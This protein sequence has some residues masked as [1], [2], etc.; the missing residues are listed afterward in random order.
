MDQQD[1]LAKHSGA[2][3]DREYASAMVD[4]HKDLIDQLEPRDRQ[5][6]TRSVEA[7]DE[8]QDEDGGRIRRHSSGPERQS[9]D[10][11]SQSIRGGLYP[12]VYAHLEAARAL[13]GSLKKR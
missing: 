9:D 6:D 13:E 12:T 11:A 2:D 8:W 7:R 1:K 5:E 4:G 10:D 3:F